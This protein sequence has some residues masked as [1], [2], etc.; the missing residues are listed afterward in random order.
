M[1]RPGPDIDKNKPPEMD[2]REAIGK[3]RPIRR[4]G[5]EVIH[6]AEVR[7]G[8]KERDGIVT[9]PPLDEGVLDPGIDRSSF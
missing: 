8:E 2:D 7:R 1:M 5:Q 3:Y 4:F 9:V 6:Q